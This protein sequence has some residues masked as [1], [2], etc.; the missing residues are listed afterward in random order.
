MCIT[1]EKLVDRYGQG[2][3]HE[4]FML[5]YKNYEVFLK[6][7]ESYET[8]LFNRILYEREYNLRAKNG[9]D[10]GIRVQTNRISDPTARKAIENLMIREAIE[11]A[12]D[13]GNILKDTDDPEKHKRD[14]LMLRMMRREYEVFNTSLNALTGREY[15]ITYRYIQKEKKLEEILPRSYHAED[16]EYGPLEWQYSGLISR[17]P[18]DSG[19]ATVTFDN[20]IPDPS[21]MPRDNHTVTEYLKTIGLERSN[22]QWSAVMLKENHD[23]YTASQLSEM[24]DEGID[25]TGKELTSDYWSFWFVKE[26]EDTYYLLTLFAKEFTQEEAE[27]IASTVSIK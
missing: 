13:S 20:G 12:N 10:I 11:E 14:I 15:R 16:S 18:A 4:R 27:E 24:K 26:G 17:L 5:I 23:L 9:E 3:P 22:T 6:L 8:G 21:S 25:L 1:E 19:M 7:I 2:N